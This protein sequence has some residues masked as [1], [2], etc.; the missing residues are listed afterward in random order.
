[1]PPYGDDNA[2]QPAAVDALTGLLTNDGLVDECR[3]AIEA[4]SG[5]EHVGIALF[6]FDGLRELTEKSGNLVTDTLVRELSRRLRATL[7]TGDHAGRITRDEF[8]VIL[9][10]LGNRLET[11]ALMA[12]LRV[13]LAEPISSG[14]TAYQPIVNYGLAYP[15][16]DGTTLEAL[17]DAAEK[18]MLVMR[19]QTRQRAKDDAVKRLATTRAA[20]SSAA[21]RVTDAELAVRHADAMLAE[22]KRLLAEA[23]LAA[24]AAL[25]LAKSL[26]VADSP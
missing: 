23:K 16:A 22:S 12:R 4:T 5:G 20:V 25:E 26:G 10:N 6:S 18:Q 15:P 21:A 8:V 1:M 17:S 11:L 13:A 9:R 7:R 19:A 2:I 3:A 24:A 14:K